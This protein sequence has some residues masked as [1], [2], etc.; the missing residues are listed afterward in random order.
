MPVLLS[1]VCH[2]QVQSVKLYSSPMQVEDFWLYSLR[3][4][5]QMGLSLFFKL[6][7]QLLMQF[8]SWLQLGMETCKIWTPE[9]N[10]LR[11][12]QL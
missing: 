9:I 6:C 1:E 11:G 5:D 2:V 4:I 12:S 10:R 7:N 8:G 3:P